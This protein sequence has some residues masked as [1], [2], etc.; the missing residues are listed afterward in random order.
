T[1]VKGHE[2]GQFVRITAAVQDEDSR[3]LMLANARRELNDFR[4][5]YKALSEFADLFAAIEA[6]LA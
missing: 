5:R 2:A 6:A 3:D 4:R 1:D